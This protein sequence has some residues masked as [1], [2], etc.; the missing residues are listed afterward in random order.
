MI[1]FCHRHSKCDS[2]LTSV[3]VEFS[4]VREPMYKYSRAAYDRF[5]E[6]PQL[7]FLFAFFARNEKAKAFAYEKF[8][9]NSDS[10]FAPRMVS[11]IDQLSE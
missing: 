1:V 6:Q 5:F 4:V 2:Y 7:C 9:E 11:E 3:P 10:R 8:L